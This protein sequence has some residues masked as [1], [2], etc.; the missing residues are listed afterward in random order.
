MLWESYRKSCGKPMDNP[1]RVLWKWNLKS[2]SHGNP[3]NIPLVLLKYTLVSA[4][5]LAYCLVIA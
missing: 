5:S 2:N 4:R 3:G 1:T